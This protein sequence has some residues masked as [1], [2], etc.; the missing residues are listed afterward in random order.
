MESFGCYFIWLTS[1]QDSEKKSPLQMSFTEQPDQTC[2]NQI[3]VSMGFKS[4]QQS[5]ALNSNCRAKAYRF[6]CQ[7]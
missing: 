2:T 6:H 7:V 4:E 3:C 5:N 1:Q